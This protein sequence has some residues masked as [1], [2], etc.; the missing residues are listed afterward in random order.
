MQSLGPN[1][2]DNVV[3]EDWMQTMGP[4]YG[5]NASLNSGGSRDVYCI[6]KTCMLVMY[7]Y[8]QKVYY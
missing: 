1:Y 7:V 8:H 4:N 3:V 5:D 6:I 2:G